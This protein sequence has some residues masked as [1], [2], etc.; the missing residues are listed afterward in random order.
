MSYFYLTMLADFV[1]AECFPV[2]FAYL[3]DS[4]LARDDNGQREAIEK[5]W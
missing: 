5:W 4:H 1:L 3:F 2:I